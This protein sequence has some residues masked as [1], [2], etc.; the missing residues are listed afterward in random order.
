MRHVI[1][2]GGIAGIT[3]AKAIRLNDPQATIV[4]ISNEKEKPYY[5]PYYRPLIPLLISGE[6]NKE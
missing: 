4:L 6:K 3:A 1:I 2:G 5:R